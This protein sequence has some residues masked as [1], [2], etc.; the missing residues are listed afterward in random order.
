[1]TMPRGILYDIANKKLAKRQSL[2]NCHVVKNCYLRNV[3]A[4]SLDK[5]CVGETGIHSSMKVFL[6][7][8]KSRL[9]VIGSGFM[10]WSLNLC[11][12]RAFAARGRELDLSFQFDEWLAANPLPGASSPSDNGR[13]RTSSG[14]NEWVA[15]QFRH[16]NV[17]KQ[18]PEIS[19]RVRNDGLREVEEL[20][21]HGRP[22]LESELWMSDQGN[23]P[24]VRRLP[25]L[26]HDG[27]WW[28][29][30]Q[31]HD[32]NGVVVHGK[33]SWRDTADI[34]YECLRECGQMV[35]N[36]KHKCFMQVMY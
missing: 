17:L 6:A 11:R 28:E 23:R 26:K 30:R 36:N 31:G 20:G 29:D 15:D 9:R 5:L 2:A 27:I 32:S 4:E 33:F 25:V 1:M 24:M 3:S 13:L 21:L 34:F 10:L 7:T 16:G 18:L 35:W 14:T 12:H 19:S 8:D 22:N